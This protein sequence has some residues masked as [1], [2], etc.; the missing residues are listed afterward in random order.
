[1]R[2]CVGLTDWCALQVVWQTD[3]SA[4]AAKARAEEQLS[5]A[6]SSMVTVGNMEAEEAEA[7][8]REEKRKAKEEAARLVCLHHASPLGHLQPCGFSP[9]GRQNRILVLMLRIRPAIDYLH[10]RGQHPLDHSWERRHVKPCCSS[11]ILLTML[12]TAHS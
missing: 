2:C 1:M 7:R 4:E 6:M 3:T 10:V 12:A 11:A 8:K 5:A 9:V